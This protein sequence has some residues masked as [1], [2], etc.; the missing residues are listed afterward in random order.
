M[1][2]PMLRREPSCRRDARAGSR[3]CAVSW[4]WNVASSVVLKSRPAYRSASPPA[5]ASA[6]AGWT[7][8]RVGCDCNVGSCSCDAGR[9]NLATC[10]PDGAVQTLKLTRAPQN[11][12]SGDSDRLHLAAAMAG[13]GW[14]PWCRCRCLKLQG[15]AA[16]P[17]LKP[18]RHAHSHQTPRPTRPPP[19]LPP[20]AAPATQQ[21]RCSSPGSAAPAGA[22]AGTAARNTTFPTRTNTLATRP[23]RSSYRYFSSCLASSLASPAASCFASAS[24]I[25]FV[26]N[27]L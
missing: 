7:A 16:W 25:A 8:I 21:P 4:L 1:S 2:A 14:R 15:Q 10:P 12:A 24:A 3:T 5:S 22:P 20:P 17:R 23:P 27:L 13:A 19:L 26:T 11:A 9:A 18:G 6:I